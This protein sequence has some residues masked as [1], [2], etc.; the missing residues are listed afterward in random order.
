[1]QNP[2]VTCLRGKRDGHGINKGKN[3]MMEEGAI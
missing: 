1:M 2:M 3:G